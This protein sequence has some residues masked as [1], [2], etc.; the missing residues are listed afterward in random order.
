MIHVVAG[1]F[2]LYPRTKE[3]KRLFS[4]NNTKIG[5]TDAKIGFSILCENV[6]EVVL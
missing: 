1:K 2:N 3:I 4:W 5:E 6:V